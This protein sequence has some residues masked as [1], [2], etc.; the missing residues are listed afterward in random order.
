HFDQRARPQGA[1][2]ALG[3]QPERPA[4]EGE[5]QEEDGEHGTQGL[6]RRAEDERGAP[7]PA[8]L[9]DEPRRSRE[10]QPDERTGE[11][12]LGA[13]DERERR[14][15]RTANCSVEGAPAP[16]GTQT[17]TR[18]EGTSDRADAAARRVL[19]L[20]VAETPQHVETELEEIHI[21]AQI[22]LGRHDV[23]RALDAPADVA[24]GD[25]VH[26]GA[27]VETELRLGG[28]RVTGR[29]VGELEAHV[30][31]TKARGHVRLHVALSGNAIAACAVAWI[32]V[33]LNLDPGPY[34]I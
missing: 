33:Q 31:E 16:R 15:H 5:T 8:D 11:P 24:A 30:V 20:P 12:R 23:I 14:G 18:P 3:D 28:A 22:V 6:G 9:V 7:N 17:K 25:E 32:D 21:R 1:A 29:A 34:R 26:P 19:R 10:E 13:A 2:H 27:H 4:A